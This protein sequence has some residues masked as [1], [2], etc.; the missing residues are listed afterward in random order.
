MSESFNLVDIFKTAWNHRKRIFWITA[1]ATIGTAALSLLLPNIYQ[2]KAIITPASPQSTNRD[3]LFGES[4]NPFVFGGTD[5]MDKILSIANSN[6]L[7]EALIRDFNLYEHYKIDPES[8]YALHNAKQKLRKNYDASQNEYGVIEITFLDEDP[9][10]AAEV[11]NGTVSTI[12]QIFGN[13]IKQNRIQLQDIYVEKIAAGNKRIEALK[14]SISRIRNRY[15][16]FDAAAQA[17]KVG[18]LITTTTTSLEMEKAKLKELQ[19]L[20]VSRRDTI[21]INTKTR[22]AGLQEQFETFMSDTSKSDF[23]LKNFTEGYEKIISLDEQK[24]ALLEDHAISIT[25][26]EQ[27]KSTIEQ[28]VPAVFVLEKAMPANRKYK[29][30][31]SRIVIAAMF[32]SFFLSLIAILI[33]ENKHKIRSHFA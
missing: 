10:F 14:D 33:R 18:E 7:K 8:R 22:I 31:R 6:E 12:D 4:V 16:I 29:P 2:A 5:D 30:K 20:G 25:Y 32:L 23:S 26:Y 19:A 17:E 3:V 13:M 9:N 1:M 21:Y 15:S 24:T 28:S 11:V 27:L